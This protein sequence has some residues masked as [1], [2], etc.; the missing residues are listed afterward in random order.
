MDDVLTGIQQAFKD[1]LDVDTTLVTIEAVPDD[2][3]GW[4]SMGHA[5]LAAS[6][7]KVFQVSLDIDDVM[8]MENVAAIVRV[9]KQKLQ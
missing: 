8:A 7:E 4:D 2:I 9:L 5:A 3:P 1:A 6:V